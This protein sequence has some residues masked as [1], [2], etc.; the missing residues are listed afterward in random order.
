MGETGGEGGKDGCR[1][2]GRSIPRA[3]RVES[4]R[5]GGLLKRGSSI[6]SPLLRGHP[7]DRARGRRAGGRGGQGR[8][9]GREGERERERERAEYAARRSASAEIPQIAFESAST[10]PKVPTV[11]HGRK[12][13]TVT[14][15]EHPRG[16]K[17]RMLQ[18]FR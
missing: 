15:M 9:G 14:R 5:D 1:E 13:Y 11:T 16:Q 2:K 8:E 17:C 10:G 4:Y 7:Q 12:V 18:V 3:R 6:H